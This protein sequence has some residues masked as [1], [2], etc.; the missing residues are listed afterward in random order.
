MPKSIYETLS[1]GPLTKTSIIIQLF[2]CSFFLS[3]WY[4]WGYVSLVFPNDF[5]MFNIKDDNSSNSS[6]IL[7]GRLL[8]RTS[9][10][11]IDVHTRILTME[12][13]GEIVEFNIFNVIQFPNDVYFVICLDIINYFM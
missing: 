7:L 1:L 10:T 2:R 3:Y 12:F 4:V 5:Y 13:D 6:P 8:L 11:K 9:R